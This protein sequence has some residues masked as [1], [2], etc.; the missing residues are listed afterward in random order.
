MSKTKQFKQALKERYGTLTKLPKSNSLFYKEGTE[1]HVYLRYSKVHN[2]NR[3]FYGIRDCDLRVL[4]GKPSVIIFLWDGQEEPL[5]IPYSHFEDIFERIEPASDGQYKVV[6][7][8]NETGYELYIPKAGRFNVD[9]YLGWRELDN[10]ISEQDAL[11]IPDLTHSQVQTLL[12]SIGVSKG[13]DIWIPQKDR[14]R[15]DNHQLAT[16]QL[17]SSIPL[18][19]DKIDYIFSEVDVIWIGKGS[20]NV[21][22]LFEI[23]HSTPIYSGLLRFNDVLLFSSQKEP[24]YNIVANKKRRSLYLRQ[25]ARP[26]FTASGLNDKCSFLEY[27]NVY[28]WFLSVKGKKL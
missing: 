18:A 6:V 14:T 24:A 16:S 10:L 2:E 15:L 12:G 21:Q 22:A 23:E 4:E 27:E 5:I 19:Y 20:N 26:T 11:D 28:R 3:T 9:N 1:V 17:M 8:L 7:Y 13:F 25:I